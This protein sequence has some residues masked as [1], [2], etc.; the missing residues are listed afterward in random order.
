MMLFL[1][2]QKTHPRFLKPATAHHAKSRT[3]TA[4]RWV[5]PVGAARQILAMS[6]SPSLYERLGG[7]SAISALIEAFYIRVLADPELAPFFRNTP[8]ERLRTMQTE[9]FSMALGGPEIYSGRP[10]G[11]IHHGRG[12]SRHHFALFVSHLLET[13]KDIG[14]DEHET[15]AVIEHINTFANEITGTSY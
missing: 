13:L 6:T 10:L 14:C 12:I 9:F 15:D 3:I 7:P 1:H 4:K 2:A 11:Y 5:A 8:M